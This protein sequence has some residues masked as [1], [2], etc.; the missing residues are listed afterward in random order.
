M[1]LG[2]RSI[3]VWGVWENKILIINRSV[4]VGE[5]IFRVGVVVVCWI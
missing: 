1:G 2:V 5:F 3:I 4:N